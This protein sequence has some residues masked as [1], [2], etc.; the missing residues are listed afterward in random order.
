M[1]DASHRLGESFLKF[2]YGSAAL[3]DQILSQPENERT[4]A[5]KA[6]VASFE[7]MG[8]LLFEPQFLS[9]YFNRNV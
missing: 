8:D 6:F 7:E 4:P 3:A 1:K 2:F 9:K 5:E